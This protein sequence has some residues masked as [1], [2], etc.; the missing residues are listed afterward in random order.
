MLTARK[1]TR[2]SGRRSSEQTARTASP[3][4]AKSRVCEQKPS[5]VSP[6]AATVR[7]VTRI[8]IG[9][10]TPT[11]DASDRVVGLLLHDAEPRLERAPAHGHCRLA[12]P[13][14]YCCLSAQLVFACPS[15]SRPSCRRSA[16]GARATSTHRRAE[17][18]STT[19]G[20]THARGTS[21]AH[22]CTH[23]GIDCGRSTPANEA[24]RVCRSLCSRRSGCSS[25][26]LWDAYSHYS[27]ILDHCLTNNH[28]FDSLGTY[29]IVTRKKNEFAFPTNSQIDCSSLHGDG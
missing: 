18:T 14:C 12:H 4:D 20:W 2:R 6:P 10:T 5:G 9:W 13:R 21:V 25:T 7:Q 23:A 28:I 16:W 27:D 8:S 26:I 19:T 3:M 22:L 29:T 11:T 15:E 1:A 24:S 17:R